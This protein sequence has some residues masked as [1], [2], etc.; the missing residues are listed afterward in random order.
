[1]KKGITTGLLLCS[2]LTAMNGQRQFPEIHIPQDAGNIARLKEIN[3][4]IWVP[5]SE[6]Y[7]TND[8][9]KYIA[10]HTPDLIRATGGDGAEVKNLAE[11]GQSSQ[12][13]FQR[14]NADNRE[15]EIA[16][17]FFERIAG[18]DMASERGIYRFTSFG[19]DG[20]RQHFYGRF[21]VFLRKM[22]G[23]WKIAVD[24]DSDE[25]G[26]IDEADFTAGLQPDVFAK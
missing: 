10:L 3:R 24:Y 26:T 13:H 25:D 7:A 14:N 6:A 18:E 8:A 1:M 16:F 20:K 11:Y 21:H 12:M 19:A 5:F 23:T 22:G 2:L 4:D 17:N 9:D 15:V